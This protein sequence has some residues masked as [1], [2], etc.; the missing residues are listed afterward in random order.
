[1]ILSKK[2]IILGSLGSL[3]V[4]IVT[5]LQIAATMKDNTKLSI[6]QKV[7]TD[8]TEIKRLLEIIKKQATQIKTLNKITHNLQKNQSTIK[9]MIEIIKE[10]DIYTTV[11][12][13]K[14]QRQMVDMG[15]EYSIDKIEMEILKKIAEMVAKNKILEKGLENAKTEIKNLRDFTIT[16]LVAMVVKTNKMLRTQ[17]EQETKITYNKNKINALAKIVQEMK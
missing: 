16:R 6:P 10:E 17:R 2:K 1:M 4:G 13:F 8:K 11:I 14:Q 12:T 5:T 9:K 7:K 15:L 3:A